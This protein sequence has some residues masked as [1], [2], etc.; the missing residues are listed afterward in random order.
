ML[1]EESVNQTPN[2]TTRDLTEGRNLRKSTY[3]RPLTCLAI[4]VLTAS[5]GLVTDT[6]NY[7]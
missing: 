1:L 3:R 4:P 7:N 5:L 6:L 2:Q